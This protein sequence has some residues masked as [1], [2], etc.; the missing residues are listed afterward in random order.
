MPHYTR[1]R[2]MKA[3]VA[4]GAALAFGSN[5]RRSRAA[6]LVYKFAHGNPDRH[7]N[8][9]RLQ[10]AADKINKAANGAL[11][12]QV[13]ANGQL[14][15]DAA[16]LSQVRSGIIQ[17]YFTSGVSISS[18]A[19]PVAAIN[20][21]PFAFQS[22][23]QVWPAMD[24][25]LGRLIRDTISKIGLRVFDKCWDSGYRQITTSTKPIVSPA[26][27]KGFKMR[28]PISSINLSMFKALGASTVSIDFNE[29]YTALQ[30]HI[31]DGEEN[32]LAFVDAGK[33][34]EVQKYC[35]LTNHIWDGDWMFANPEAW[36]ALPKDLQGLVDKGF[37][38]ESAQAREDIR[39]A[40]EALRGQLE[41]KG[42]IFNSPD[43]QPFR[44]ALRSAGLY[45]D[46]RNQLGAEAWSV[47]EKYTGPLV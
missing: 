24:G 30:T 36:A 7:P 35:S 1:R 33:L 47:L 39:L 26:D 43:L 2:L 38:E 28:V 15:L 41:K 5:P 8:S 11:E 37:N 29:L 10:A 12:I 23:A 25:D 16:M 32:P 3:T 6:G 44:E 4:G 40:N 22:Y 34:Y 27:L 31:A 42:M 19:G 17:F 18:A 46:W 9:I 20:A 13:F 14:G 21:M 45:K